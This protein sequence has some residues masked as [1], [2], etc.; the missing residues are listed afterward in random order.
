M[1]W[2]QYGGN[3]SED[4]KEFLRR[5]VL[6]SFGLFLFFFFFFLLY[7]CILYFQYSLLSFL[8]IFYLSLFRYEYFGSDFA[9][10]DAVRRLALSLDRGDARNH[11]P[12]HPKK[13]SSE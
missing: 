4:A 10:S 1:S 8:Y 6:S 5:S 13:K 2:L 11:I 3:F 12:C 9:F 7:L